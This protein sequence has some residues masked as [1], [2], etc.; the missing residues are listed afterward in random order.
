MGDGLSFRVVTPIFI[1]VGNPGLRVTTPRENRFLRAKIRAGG[2]HS[3]CFRNLS[4]RVPRFENR[5]AKMEGS[6]FHRGL[7]FWCRV[8]ACVLTTTRFGRVPSQAGLRPGSQKARVGLPGGAPV[9]FP[10][11]ATTGV[12]P[13][14]YMY[15]TSFLDL[16]SDLHLSCLDINLRYWRNFLDFIVDLGS[17]PTE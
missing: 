17:G 9:G 6:S 10:Y 1:N 16:V 13:T 4:Y 11:L 7:I 15:T 5:L 14:L 12:A 2:S 3:G 8:F